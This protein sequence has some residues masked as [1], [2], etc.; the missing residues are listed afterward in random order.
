MIRRLF[1][2]GLSFKRSLSSALADLPNPG[3]R[4]RAFFMWILRKLV[5]YLPL[6]QGSEESYRI[7]SDE[8]LPETDTFFEVASNLSI[9]EKFAILINHPSFEIF[10]AKIGEFAMLSSREAAELLWDLRRKD[11]EAGAGWAGITA[12]G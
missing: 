1:F 5:S 10:L 6:R 12:E 3:P 8:E 9:K 2:L 7:N 4:R 11:I